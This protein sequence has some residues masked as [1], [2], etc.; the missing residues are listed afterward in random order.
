MCFVV[1]IVY[2]VGNL[3]TNRGLFVRLT[4]PFR[5]M[6]NMANKKLNNCRHKLEMKFD[7]SLNPCVR[8]Q[9]ICLFIQVRPG[10]RRNQDKYNIINKAWL[11]NS[12]LPAP[13]ET[14]L[15]L[16]KSRLTIFVWMCRTRIWNWSR[17][18]RDSFK[19]LTRNH[20]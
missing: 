3:R 14:L 20:R 10:P 7:R 19:F 5:F 6:G 15:Y 11:E 2:S 18:R 13:Y 1:A 4:G 12:T 8:L 16:Y 17:R 9:S